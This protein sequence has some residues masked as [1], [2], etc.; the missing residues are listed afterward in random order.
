[1]DI[2]ANLFGSANPSVSEAGSIRYTDRQFMIHETDR[3]NL[4]MVTEG[5][6]KVEGRLAGWAR[7]CWPCND[8]TSFFYSVFPFQEFLAPQRRPYVDALEPHV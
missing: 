6:I 2:S 7:S 5:I 8:H 4:K 1:M 3:D